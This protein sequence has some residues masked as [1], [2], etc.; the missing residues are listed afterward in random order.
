MEVDCQAKVCSKMSRALCQIAVQ[1]D[2]Y[3]SAQ[4]AGGENPVHANQSKLSRLVTQGA[5]E[6]NRVEN[7]ILL[8]VDQQ[9]TPES[10]HKNPRSAS[11]RAA[12]HERVLQHTGRKSASKCMIAPMPKSKTSD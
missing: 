8:L 5:P 1:L 10:S 3:M 4:F 9:A 6:A 7:N 12:R 2:Y 11:R